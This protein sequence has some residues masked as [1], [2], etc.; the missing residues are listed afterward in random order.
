MRII[1]RFRILRSTYKAMRKQGERRLRFII[2]IGRLGCT[3]CYFSINE[4][5][6]RMTL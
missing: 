4:I 1:L 3:T 6:L 2:W 5:S